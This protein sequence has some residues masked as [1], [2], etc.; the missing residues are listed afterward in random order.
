MCF[1]N[2]CWITEWNYTFE[3]QGLERSGVFPKVT[4]QAGGRSHPN[5][6]SHWKNFCSLLFKDPESD[7]SMSH[8]QTGDKELKV[9]L[10]LTHS[11]QLCPQVP[12]EDRA[13]CLGKVISNI[14]YIV[15]HLFSHSSA[16]GLRSGKSHRYCCSDFQK[17]FWPWRQTWKNYCQK[18]AANPIQEF[19]RGKRINK[20][21]E[22]GSHT[23]MADPK[24]QQ[25]QHRALL[26]SLFFHSTNVYWT[27]TLCQEVSWALGLM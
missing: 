2:V 24:S 8:P 6:T 10:I 25:F 27:T 14:G 21:V 18:P 12:V 26:C 5:S 1:I 11:F 9:R 22:R 13:S 7:T 4:W 17:L 16:Q 23:I 3:N 20:L 15:V 19:H